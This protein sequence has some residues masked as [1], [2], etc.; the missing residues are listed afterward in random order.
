M[1]YSLQITIICLLSGIFLAGGSGHILIQKADAESEPDT[2][3]G[4]EISSGGEQATHYDSGLLMAGD[5]ITHRFESTGIDAW[6]KYLQQYHPLNYGVEGDTTWEL[7]ERLE[8]TPPHSTDPQVSTILIGVNDLIAGEN[9]VTV[10]RN[11]QNISG[12]ISEKYPECRIFVFCIF[13]IGKTP[14]KIR[15]IINETNSLL[16]NSTYPKNVRVV[17]LTPSFTDKNGVLTDTVS[18]DQLHLNRNGYEIWGRAIY[19][20][21]NNST[22]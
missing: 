12:I 5:S 11:I 21:I 13:P 1:K 16:K 17:D 3:G 14:G 7:L 2:R 6:K 22:D 8:N 9:P 18:P 19:E 20:L 10:A 4:E 15:D